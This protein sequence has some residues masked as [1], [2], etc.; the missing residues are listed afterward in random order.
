MVGHEDGIRH[1]Y[2]K[3]AQ[4]ERLKD[5][6]GPSM[7]DDE[8][9]SLHVLRQRGRIIKAFHRKTTRQDSTLLASSQD[10]A[11][12]MTARTHLSINRLHWW[13]PTCLRHS[14]LDNI[15]GLQPNTKVTRSKDCVQGW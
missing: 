11:G 12:H 2:D 14:F 10:A 7:T 4:P 3:L 9:R 1:S 8:G 6:A 15:T 5:A 13:E